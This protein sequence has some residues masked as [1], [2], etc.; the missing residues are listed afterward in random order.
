[1]YILSV[2]ILGNIHMHGASS[3]GH[4]YVFLYNNFL[5]R[6]HGCTQ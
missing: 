3:C 4:V 5:L 2:I 6:M 1:M